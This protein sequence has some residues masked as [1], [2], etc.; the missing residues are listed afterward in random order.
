MDSNS[1]T[2][3]IKGKIRSQTSRIFD[4]FERNADSRLSM[5][6]SS[7]RGDESAAGTDQLVPL[8]LVSAWMK[9]EMAN[10][11]RC[12]QTIHIGQ[13]DE[14]DDTTEINDTLE[15]LLL[16][17]HG[18]TMMHP[19]YDDLLPLKREG[20]Q[21]LVKCLRQYRSLKSRLTARQV[22]DTTVQ[23]SML[24]KSQL[25]GGNMS[26]LSSKKPSPLNEEFI[27]GGQSRPPGRPPEIRTPPLHPTS[28]PTAAIGSIVSPQS[29]E[30][31]VPIGLH[32]LASF[33]VKSESVCSGDTNDLL[34]SLN[35][36][37]HT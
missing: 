9:A 12:I 27:T 7:R 24:M 5:L 29:T 16:T 15:E 28:T 19:V 33:R 8:S 36:S 3:F 11:V 26:V 30:S 4:Q 34:L 2:D 14:G 18:S 23:K 1:Q 21:S 32:D 25:S 6:A 22:F 37:P 35:N 20:F 10:W 17:E 31:A 13:L